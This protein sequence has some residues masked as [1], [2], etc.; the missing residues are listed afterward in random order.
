MTF[1]QLSI[2]RKYFQQNIFLP[3]KKNLDVYLQYF[4][5]RSIFQHTCASHRIRINSSNINSNLI[6]RLKRNFRKFSRTSIRFVELKRLRDYKKNM[7]GG[8]RISSYVP[9]GSPGNPW[10]SIAFRKGKPVV[11]DITVNGGDTGRGVVGGGAGWKKK[12]EGKN[13]GAEKYSWR[14]HTSVALHT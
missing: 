4:N 10:L 13:L 9:H 14:Y 11:G 7:D 1:T 6:F 3:R 12:T 8:T 2:T 5:F